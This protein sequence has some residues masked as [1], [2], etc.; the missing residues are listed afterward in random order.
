MKLL[1]A[2][3]YYAPAWF[4]G[5]PVVVGHTMVEDLLA[6]GH[7]V[8]VATTDALDASA[9][10]PAGEPPLPEG[11]EVV[12]FRNVSHRLAAGAMAWQPHGYRSWIR[13]NAG[14]FDVALGHDFYSVISAAG[15]RAA[16]AAGT[17]WVLQPLGSLAPS[18]ERG[19][20]LVKR[21]FLR[22]VGRGTFAA[23]AAGIHSTERERRD[24]LDA[25]FDPAKL[26]HLPLPLEMPGPVEGIGRAERPTVVCVARLDP[27]KGIEVLIRAAALAQVR[28]ELIGPGDPAPYERVAREAGAEVDFLGFVSAE[29]KRERL[30]RAHAGALLSRS[31][32]LPLA[33]IEAMACG[34]PVVLSEGCN[35]PEADGTA[36]VVTAREPEAAAAAIARVLVDRDRFAEGALG[37][38]AG[39]RRERVMPQMAAL[40]ERLAAA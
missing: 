17:P 38:A 13:E 20:P 40:F 34:A 12:R 26:V 15:A 16:A 6:M 25:G 27:I 4:F 8:T 19:R 31:E 2:T 7:E 23:A 1:L 33:A 35:L 11:A 24:F 36:G 18:A 14:R 39:F 9:R 10:V 21:A 29:E 37:F 22:A 30:T 5:G 3:P 28:L 32:G